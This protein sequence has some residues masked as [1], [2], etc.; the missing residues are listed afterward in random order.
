M[1]VTFWSNPGKTTPT[2]HATTDSYPSS[3]LHTKAL[4]C[5]NHQIHSFKQQQQQASKNVKVC[6]NLKDEE[7]KIR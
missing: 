5:R 4:S 1:A 6:N 7:Y 3:D 2:I